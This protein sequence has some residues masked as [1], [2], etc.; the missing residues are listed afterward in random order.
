MK[1]KGIDLREAPDGGLLAW[2]QVLG[3]FFLCFSSSGLT[4]AF[5]VWVDYLKHGSLSNYSESAISWI[6]TV[7][8]FL[9]VFVVGM[10]LVVLGFMIASTAHQYYSIFISLGAV[11]GTGGAC[12][13]TPGVTIVAQYFT[14]KRSTATGIASA[15]GSVGGLVLPILFRKITSSIGYGWANRVIGFMILTFL[16]ISLVLLKPRTSPSTERKLLDLKAITEPAYLLFSFGLF[17]VWTGMYQPFFYI[18]LYA[19]EVLHVS[20]DM[21]SYMLAFMGAGSIFGRILI[22][23]LADRFGAIQ[24]FLPV[25]FVLGSL[26]FVWAAIKTVAGTVAFCV[27]YGFFSGASVS[28]TPVMLAAISPDLSVLGT[29]IGMAFSLA[30]FGLLIG[31]PISGVLLESRLGYMAVQVF[32]VH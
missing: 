16:L 25:I 8:G 18:P 32:S 14:T 10:I 9:M 5:G 19:K 1:P 17:T 12:L 22:N 30:S 27:I 20:G 15:G 6:G 2:L 24:C 3:A 21:P 13:F 29:R 23:V 31:G 11:V 26:L 4:V 7:Q 28:L